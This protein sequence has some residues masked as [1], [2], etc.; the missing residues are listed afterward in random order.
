M[1]YGP[2]HRAEPAPLHLVNEVYGLVG[3]VDSLFVREITARDLRHHSRRTWDTSAAS[4]EA[5]PGRVIAALDDDDVEIVV[6][7]GELVGEDCVG[8]I[9]LKA[10]TLDVS[11]AACSRTGVERAEQAL[12]QALPPIDMEAQH[13]VPVAFWSYG[14]RDV[15]PTIRAIQVPAWEEVAANY[16]ASLS[17][18]LEDLMEERVTT[19]FG[20]LMLWHGPPGTGKTYALRALAWSWRAWCR[21][22]YIVDPDAFFRQSGEYLLP[23]LLDDGDDERLWRLIVL[24][25]AGELLAPDAKERV[26]QDLSR[27]LNVLD[28]LIG[29]GLRL[30]FL[31]TTNEKLT[32]VHPAITRPGRSAVSLSFDAFPP[33]EARAWLERHGSPA[34]VRGPLSLAE[35][36]AASAGRPL[37]HEAPG[38]G[39]TA[40]LA[41]P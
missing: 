21:V 27:L 29:Q 20:N 9:G 26:G 30:L 18:R 12:R 22:N 13:E 10:Q 2:E 7:L 32:R 8:M 24:E 31:I 14:N 5:C 28:G 41:D 4:L 37:R 33:D 40:D 23:V 3:L 35:L 17:A 16:P 39:F 1:P 36:Y 34:P 11:L 15:G 38:V 6:D 19:E 25:D